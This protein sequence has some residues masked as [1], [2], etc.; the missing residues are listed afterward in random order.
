MADQPN[1]DPATTLDSPPVDDFI[2]DGE[3]D[4]LNLPG[5]DD[6][7][8]SLPD[9]EPSKDTSTDTEPVNDDWKASMSEDYG[10]DVSQFE[11][12]EEAEQA[13]SQWGSQLLSAPPVSPSDTTAAS[14]PPAAPAP[15]STP[16][17]TFD[18]D[19]L[20]ELDPKLADAFKFMQ[21]ENKRLQTEVENAKSTAAQ[22]SKDVD[23][24]ESQKILHDFDSVVAE[25]GGTRYG[26]PGRQNMFQEIAT[27]N[28]ARIVGQIKG[29]FH[30]DIKKA[31]KWAIAMDTGSFSSSKKTPPMPEKEAPKPT[32]PVAPTTPSKSVTP[33]SARST[34]QS[35]G[36]GLMNNDE[37][38]E[39][40]RRIMGR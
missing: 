11:T 4:S 3:I 9:G 28:L 12:R 7:T 26:V 6:L 19:S 15:T 33:S 30:G 14:P 25:A 17:E 27:G 34:S 5:D 10:V 29:H 2:T 24:A 20:K 39:G 31:T 21:S 37:F 16:P 23:M 32:P 18:F 40:A 36:G 8:D 22:V 13:L 35:V 1:G 38:L